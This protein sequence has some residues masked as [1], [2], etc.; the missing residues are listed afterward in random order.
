MVNFVM[1]CNDSKND[2]LRD[3]Y[4]ELFE[5]AFGDAARRLDR[6]VAAK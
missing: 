1:H 6:E 3:L 4:K 5:I 2:S